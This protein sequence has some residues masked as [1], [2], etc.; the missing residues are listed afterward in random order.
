MREMLDERRRILLGRGASPAYRDS[1]LFASVEQLLRRSLEERPD[2]TLLLQD[3]LNDEE[4]WVL[5]TKPLR[6][7]SHRKL[8]G[9]LILLF[10]R[11]VAVPMTR[12]LYDYLLDNLRRQQR[13]NRL[14]FACV[15]ELAVENARLRQD[16][17]RR[18]PTRRDGAEIR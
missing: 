14:L 5:D 9:P 13:I 8:L 18:E 11:R 7:T 10:K 16:M 15:E 1:N 3:L 12:W 6:L 2:G 4:E 17:E